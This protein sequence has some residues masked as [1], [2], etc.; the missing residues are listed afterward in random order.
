V[1]DNDRMKYISLEQPNTSFDLSKRVLPYDNEKNNEILVEID[2]N[3]FTSQD[4]GYISQFSKIISGDE[5]LKD[6]I[7][8]TFELSNMKITIMGLETYENDLIKTQ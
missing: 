1:K 4:M 7:G 5:E 2:G 3:T 8:G 6:H